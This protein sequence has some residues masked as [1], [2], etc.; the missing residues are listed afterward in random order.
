MSTHVR[1]WEGFDLLW[2][3]NQD[4]ACRWWWIG[5][6][7]SALSGEGFSARGADFVLCSI[8]LFQPASVVGYLPL[9]ACIVEQTP[10]LVN[11]VTILSCRVDP[12][13]LC[14]SNGCLERMCSGLWLERDCG[15]P[16]QELFQDPEFV[17]RYVV[18]LARELKSCFMSSIRPGLLSGAGSAGRRASSL[19]HCEENWTAK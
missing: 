8:S 7:W 14:G 12:F 15:R 2:P 9:T 4:F 1:G 11:W 3:S 17:L 19:S 5:T 16:A 18:N 10:S 6:A 13:C